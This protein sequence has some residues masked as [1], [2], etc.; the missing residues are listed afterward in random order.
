MDPIHNPFVP[1]AGTPPPE[2]TGRS[3]LLDR[4]RVALAR[5]KLGRSSKSFIA[6]GLRGVGKT[7]LLSRI[8]A[9]CAGGRLPRLR[10]RGVR[11]TKPSRNCSSRS[12]A[13]CCWTSIGSVLSANT[14]SA[15]SACSRASCR[16]SRSRSPTQSLPW[17]STA[18]AAPPTAATWRRTCQSCSPPSAK[19]PV[20]AAQAVALIIDEVQYLS[21]RDMGALIMALHRTDQD[22]LPLI[23]VAAGLPA[24]RRPDRALQVLCRTAVRL[25]SGGRLV[26]RGRGPRPRRIRHASEGVAFTPGALDRISS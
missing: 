6:V 2:L 7:V 20:T 19:R 16:P 8:R 4:A 25:S 11:R 15:A 12:F 24:G 22:K 1:G 5:T 14:S 26:A 9:T 18:S 23:L 17:T 21:E 3:V 10:D 13:A